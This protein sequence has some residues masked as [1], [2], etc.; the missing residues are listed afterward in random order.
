MFGDPF[1]YNS[2]GC[3]GWSGYSHKCPLHCG[4]VGV[5]TVLRPFSSSSPLGDEDVERIAQRVV[6]LLRAKQSVA[7]PSEDEPPA[8]PGTDPASEL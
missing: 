1:P 4:E 5:T 3:G 8:A 7:L 2:C 6:E